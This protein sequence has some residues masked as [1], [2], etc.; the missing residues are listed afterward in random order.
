MKPTE[1]PAET[2][3]FCSECGTRLDVGA[4]FCH[5]CGL[6][7]AS[8]GGAA[9]AV[10]G[11]P[12][13][14]GGGVPRIVAWSVPALTIFALLVVVLAKASSSDAPPTTGAPGAMPLGAARA[15]DISSLS[16]QE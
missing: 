13:T 7:V 8:G 10:A 12:A 6:P 16:P 3:A 11:R 5:Q 14:A 2:R 4:R 1:T 15:T 9:R